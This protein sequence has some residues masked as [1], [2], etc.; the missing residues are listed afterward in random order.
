METATVPVPPVIETAP[1]PEV[2]I[3][4][5]EAEEIETQPPQNEPED[6]PQSDLW[7]LTAHPEVQTKSEELARHEAM[8][9]EVQA[10]LDANDEPDSSAVTTELQMML[11][12]IDEAVAEAEEELL[13]LVESLEAGDGSGAGA[14]TDAGAEVPVAPTAAAAATAAIVFSAAAAFQSEATVVGD[15]GSFSAAARR[16]FEEKLAGSLQERGFAGGP[17]SVR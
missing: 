12:E 15:A 6:E 2:A 8:R 1:A 13:A 4:A 9:E 7:A 17:L 11:L 3:S 10:M 14:G 16:V 5:H